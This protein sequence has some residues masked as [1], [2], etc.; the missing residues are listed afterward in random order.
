LAAGIELQLL[1]LYPNAVLLCCSYAVV[2]IFDSAA[3]MMSAAKSGPLGLRAYR[4]VDVKASYSL[5]KE[6]KLLF[7]VIQRNVGPI[8]FI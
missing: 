3:A 7:K 8:F 4:Y 6:N 1:L 2:N 5:P